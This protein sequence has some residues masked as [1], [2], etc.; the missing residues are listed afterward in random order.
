MDG[1]NVKWTIETNDAISLVTLKGY[2]NE[3]FAYDQLIEQLQQ[4]KNT[5]LIIDLK[6]IR[7]IN[8]MGIR[9]WFSFA[10][11]LK[12]HKPVKLVNLSNSFRLALSPIED[13]AQGF[14]VESI[15]LDMW[16]T[17]CAE[18][19]E[20]LL[21]KADSPKSDSAVPCP[22]CDQECLLDVARIEHFFDP[23]AC[24]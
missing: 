5:E 17:E 10:R 6:S 20:I 7:R 2:I 11:T 19:F 13:F 22:H 4:I 14:V 23:N 3:E 21:E 1:T 16:C 9:Q 18:D 24:L 12:W 15:Y 8:S